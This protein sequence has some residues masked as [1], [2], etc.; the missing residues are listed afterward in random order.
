MASIKTD[1]QI[2]KAIKECIQTGKQINLTVIGYTGLNIRIRPNKKSGASVEFR[3]RYKHPY[4]NERPNIT[5]GKY[6]SLTLAQAKTAHAENLA[7]LAQNIDPDSYRK[8]QALEQVQAINNTFAVV[9]NNWLN[10]EKINK[11]P[12]QTTLNNWIRYSNVLIK[13]FGNYPIATITAPQ[14][15][16][17][18]KR[19]QLNTNHTANRV[20]GIANRIFAYAVIHNIITYNPL[21]S[22]QGAS[23]LK[24]NHINNNSALTK[25]SEVAC[26]LNDIDNLD[27]VKQ[28]FN[29]A[30]LQLLALTF[31]RVGDLCSM[32]W[33]D[34]DFNAKQWIFS[35]QKK[36]NRSNMV[37]SLT[38]PLAP[39]AIAILKDIQQI[40]GDTEYVFYNPR[41]KKEHYHDKA[42][43]NKTLNH[44][45][46]NK[47]GIGKDYQQGKG[48]FKVHCPHGFRATAK[49]LLTEVLKY[50]E[51][52]TE[53]Q[54]GHSMLNKYNRAYNRME[55]IEER[56][57]M[58][59]EWANYLDD[60]K[61]TDFGKVSYLK[62]KDNQ[63][64]KTG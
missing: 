13:D 17:L 58:M 7:L 32:K 62:V 19:I 31:V 42:Q 24:S 48:Y 16:N 10:D 3:H 30:I 29:K 18:C 21:A 9:A 8:Q 51:L 5:L 54:L 35:P 26:L 14:I 50:D 6:P 22:L 37:D 47:Q 46:M 60:L 45:T 36:G 20:K 11:N 39:Q 43:I 4:T 12:T 27:S 59:T 41:R 52:I 23:V 63:S 53:L 38:V 34:V 55:G 64:T 56:T 44:K 1:S 57:K 28:T 49:T 25:P 2:K 15:I 40:T 61:N 33:G